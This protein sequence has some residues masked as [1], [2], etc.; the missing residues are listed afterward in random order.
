MASFLGIGEIPT[1]MPGCARHHHAAWEFVYYLEGTGA[2][3]VGDERVPFEPGVIVALPPAIPHFERSDGGYRNYHL[4]F[5]DYAPPVPGVPRC[6]DDAQQ[7]ALH[8]LRLL[9]REARVGGDGA[10]PICQ[11]L[12]QVVLGYIARW[13]AASS[14]SDLVHALKAALYARY[15]DPDFGVGVALRQLPCA[16][17]HARRVFRQATGRSPLQ[18]LT[19]LRLQEAQQLLASGSGVRDTAE[20]VGMPDA[21]YFSRVF[22][23]HVGMSPSRWADAVASGTLPPSGAWVGDEA[24]P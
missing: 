18:W 22:S 23:R 15:A 8:L 2:I 7:T 12:A 9:H 17:D 21:Y 3:T 16:P 14:G 20:R 1:R 11:Q 6:R 19:D 24:A 5:A 4:L 10:R 13:C